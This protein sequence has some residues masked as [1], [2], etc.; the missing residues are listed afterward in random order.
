M[1]QPRKQEFPRLT[2]RFVQSGDLPKLLNMSPEEQAELNRI[3][4]EMMDVMNEAAEIESM[5]EI[6]SLEA[7][8]AQV[9]GDHHPQALDWIQQAWRRGEDETRL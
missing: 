9:Q 7:L 4:D 2:I 5:I 3:M 1:T 8:D 6:A